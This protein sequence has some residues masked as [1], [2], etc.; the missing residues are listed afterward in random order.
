ERR[1][2]RTDVSIMNLMN[3]RRAEMPNSA[4]GVDAHCR[5]TFRP[6]AAAQTDP[7]VRT[8]CDLESLVAIR[9]SAENSR[10]PK[11]RRHRRIIRVK[12]DLNPQFL[13]NGD[14]LSYE[15]RVVVPDLIAAVLAPKVERCG[16][17]HHFQAARPIGWYPHLWRIHVENP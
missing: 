7:D 16:R 8:A 13:G 1:Q 15:I 4:G 10:N 14:H 3:A 5:P 17:S 11:Q 9:K 12:A 2:G 6:R